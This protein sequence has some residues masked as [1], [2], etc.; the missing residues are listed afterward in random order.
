[1]IYNWSEMNW[2]KRLENHKK[3]VIDE[4]SNLISNVATTER[5][6]SEFLKEN[7]GFFFSDFSEIVAI[8]E[9]ELGRDFRIDFV[10]GTCMYSYGFKYKLIELE[11]P[12]EPAFVKKGNYYEPSP[13]LSGAIAQIMAWKTW[14][15]NNGSAAKEVFPSKKFNIYNEP[16]FEFDIIIGRRSDDAKYLEA[17]NVLKKENDINVRSFDQMTEWAWYRLFMDYY[18][19]YDGTMTILDQMI[20][21]IPFSKPFQARIGMILC[22]TKALRQHI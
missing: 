11:S 2:K 5:N 10:I 14:I 9:L 8:S 7:P 12:N 19:P 17:I 22:E 20:I 13:R 1:M 18:L 21:R 3:S 6:C 16:Q 15:N 4:W